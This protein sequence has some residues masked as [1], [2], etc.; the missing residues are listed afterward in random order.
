MFKPP[1]FG[2]LVIFLTA[3]VAGNAKAISDK[4]NTYH[5]P[6]KWKAFVGLTTFR[7]TI[8]FSEGMI[9]LGSNG[10][11]FNSLNDEW[12]G[13]YLL[14]GKTGKIV[15]HIRPT[16]T[17]DTDVN[18][19]AI[20]QDHLFFGNDEGQFFSYTK[21]G[22]KRWEFQADGD[23]EGAPALSDLQGDG[24]PDVVFATE[25]GSVFALNGRSGRRLWS[26]SARLEPVEGKYEYLTSSSFIAS[27]AL[28]DVNADGVR[29]VLIGA[30]NATFYAL[31][32]K[33]GE[34]IWRYHTGSGIHSSAMVLAQ[35][36]NL[37]I[38]FAE[39]YSSLHILDQTGEKRTENEFE[40]PGGGIQGFFSSPVQTPL[41]EVFIGS[42]W[43]DHGG[44]E[45][46]FGTDMDGYW[47]FHPYSNRSSRKFKGLGRISSTAFVADI[48][49]QFTP[50]VGLVSERGRLV[51]LH[52]TGEIIADFLL[53]EGVEAT[54]LVADVDNDF[55]TELLI[56]AY[57][58][59]LYCFG[60]EAAGR[61]EWGQFRGNNFNTGVYQDSYEDE[62]L[63]ASKGVT[64]GSKFGPQS[65]AS[66]STIPWG[67][68]YA[69]VIAVA[70]YDDLLAYN[71]TSGSG[72]LHDLRY[73]EEDG[74][75][76]V[77]FLKDK[78]RSG[79]AWE[80]YQHIGPDATTQSV[81][82]TIDS[83][84]ARATENDLIF[85]FFSGHARRGPEDASEVYLLTYDFN[86]DNEYSGI[87]Y[88]WLKRKIENS[89]AKHLIA[90]IDAC[91][92]GTVGFAKGSRNPDHDIL[93]D[94][95][96]LPPTKLIFTSGRGSQRA[97]ED[98]NLG[99]S[100][101]THYLLEGMKGKAEDSD[102]DGF[103]DLGELER[104]V[105]ESVENHT[106]NNQ[107]MTRQSPRLWERSGLLPENFPVS[108]RK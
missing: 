101:F 31:N 55:K 8:S 90:F 66:Q 18:G 10:T 48:L 92:S 63:V 24:Y 74:K 36:R 20:F 69:I 54:P 14:D 60:T 95:R 94:L 50:Q 58:G 53:P 39:A 33:T 73:S 78:E 76:F 25:A 6:L 5:L 102:H 91:R 105:R 99:M 49:D 16:I 23:V 59:Y 108:I 28:Y 87:E 43:W 2:L 15:R 88:N 47:V 86:Y 70:D 79:G 89:E 37:R 64:T 85:I 104:Y 83:I 75:A 46:E 21:S 100:V 12:D 93:G 7:T 34:V 57:D 42:A 71:S 106:A 61:I 35:G 3:A 17:G 68:K 11:R 13:V 77:R 103:V 82:R 4:T 80:I 65:S 32:G 19:V 81:K 29:D 45:G 72:R 98:Q 107:K 22:E 67:K 97:W 44:G 1:W 56:A 41:G 51:L 84:L 26:F 30:R 38:L 62:F 52:S 27:P 40:A 96:N 9:I